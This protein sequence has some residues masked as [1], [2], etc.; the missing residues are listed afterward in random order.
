MSF[1]DQVKQAI[2]KTIAQGARCRNAEDD[3]CSYR[4]DGL[5][6]VIGHMIPNDVY[7]CDMEGN[8]V[9]RLLSDHS[10]FADMLAETFQM[11]CGLY[12][13]QVALLSKLQRIHD[14]IAIDCWP[15]AFHDAVAD[16]L[17]QI[18]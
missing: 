3:V 16:Y 13:E 2:E 1:I 4:S 15:E 11:R 8:D 12:T 6:C 7:N 18:S 14:D 9:D 10:L 17:S 5:K